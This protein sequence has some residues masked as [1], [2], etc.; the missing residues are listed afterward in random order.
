MSR[1]PASY[2]GSEKPRIWTPPLRRLTPK[3]SKGFA[4]IAFVEALAAAGV[5]DRAGNPLALMPWQKWTA[6]HALELLPNGKYRF[7]IVLILVSRQNGK[8]TLL[9]VL[10]LWRMLEDGARMVFGTSTNSEYARESWGKTVEL[11]QQRDHALFGDEWPHEDRWLTPRGPLEKFSVKRGALDTRMT[12]RT[13]NAVY[14]VGTASRTG[15]RSLSIDLGITDELREHRP[16]GE[17]TGFEAW[18]A[19]TGTTTAAPDGQIW[20]LSNAGEADSVV[21]NQLQARAHDEIATGESASSDLFLA[22]YSADPDVIDLDLYDQRQWAQANPA[23][24]HT[25]TWHTLEGKSKL[26]IGIVKTEHLCIGV[27]SLAG[28]IPSG[29]W[30]ACETDRV[31]LS[32]LRRRTALVVEVSEDL[33]HVSLVAAAEDAAGVVLYDVVA[34]WDSV[35]AATDG[36]P[37]V[38]RRVKPRVFGW[39]PGGPAGAL[40]PAVAKIRRFC[41][42]E[43]MGETEQKQACMGLFARVKAGRARHGRDALLTGHM[44]AAGKQQVGDGWRFKRRGAGRIDCAFAAAGAGYLAANL[45]KPAKAGVVTTKN[46][47]P[48]RNSAA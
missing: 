5:T 24:G 22:E 12:L 44:T 33:E 42:V 7:D 11:A 36:L 32:R 43:D 29:A 2:V 28:A 17:S 16:K 40:A 1:F 15:G 9:Q 26:P 39:F 34:A 14:K 13:N 4:L 19:I 47:P 3:T 31:D 38:V 18:A 46:P 25:I 45:P 41:K 37:T 35:Q 23:V 10:A 6:I 27:Q 20:A 21:L 8:T 48:A 30:K